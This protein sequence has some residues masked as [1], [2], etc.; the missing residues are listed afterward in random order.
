MGLGPLPERKLAPIEI[1]ERYGHVL[2]AIAR[3]SIAHGL[4][5][6][7]PLAVEES[8]YPENLRKQ[9]ASFVTLKNEDRLRGCI[10]KA[11]AR[12][13]LVVDVAENAFAA[14]F[15]DPR[16]PPLDRSEFDRL[17]IEV[18]VLG[19]PEPIAAADEDALIAAL[20]PGVDGLILKC[21]DRQG[22]FLPAVW[23]TLPD[24]RAFVAQLKIKAGLDPDE[25]PVGIRAFRFETATARAPAARA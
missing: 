8:T 1:A 4:A 12:L 6:H 9:M 22:L 14:A 10:G 25:W 18:S 3:D 21:A 24:P 2:T 15:E 16:F 20:R 11:Q 13:P 5:A 7:E 19:P 17:A 23:K